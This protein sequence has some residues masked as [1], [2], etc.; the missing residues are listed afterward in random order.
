MLVFAFNNTIGGSGAGARN[1]ISGNGTGVRVDTGSGNTVIQGNAIGTAADGVSSLPNT[2]DGVFI[3]GGNTTTVGGTTAAQANVIAFNGA[4]G[5]AVASGTANRITLNSVRGNGGLGI[6][7]GT[8]GV[9][10]N[11]NNDPDSGANN[12]QNYPVLASATVDAGVTTVGGQLNSVISRPY[13]IDFYNAASCDPSGFGEG[14]THIGSTSVTT[15]TN[16]VG[17][18]VSLPAQAAGSFISATATSSDGT[19]EFSACILVVAGPAP[20][21]WTGAVSTDWSNA[22]NW[23]PNGVP[24]GVSFVRIPVTTIQPTVTGTST[25]NDLIVDLGVSVTQLSGVMLTV[26][27]DATINGT[28]V[29]NPGSVLVVGRDLFASGQIAG[30]GSL[31]NS[32]VRLNGAANR[33]RGTV[34][35]SV[36]EVTGTT[37][38]AGV[39]NIGNDIDITGTLIVGPNTIGG[40]D[41]VRTLGSG[42]IVM[43]NAAARSQRLRAACFPAVSARSPRAASP[44]RQ[45]RRAAIR[46]RCRPVRTIGSPSCFPSRSP[47]RDRARDSLI[48]DG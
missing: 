24:S 31:P 21:L 1:V 42:V 32:V 28:V 29:Q 4:R 30:T 18:T 11:D 10:A 44:A 17:F 26:N 13:T 14:D 25:V 23:N 36:V 34:N 37:T 40:P 6:D 12:L 33:L 46:R 35:S 47:T 19:S 43:D 27:R 9:T 7:L 20:I 22:G 41:A 45:S 38:I 2:S 48:S 5:V 16:T 15:L 39:T 3:S 8:V